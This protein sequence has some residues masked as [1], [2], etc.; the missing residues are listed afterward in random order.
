[1]Q[2][3]AFPMGRKI[4]EQ[5]SSRKQAIRFP[6]PHFYQAKSPKNFSRK[7]KKIDNNYLPIDLRIDQIPMQN[8]ILDRNWRGFEKELPPFFPPNPNSPST[9]T[10]PLLRRRRR[11]ATTMSI[12]PL[13]LRARSDG[14][15]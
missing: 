9:L 1:M 11:D 4:N 2:K 5:K 6:F 10:P 3:I 7:K 8:D 14:R 15:D 13:K 12:K